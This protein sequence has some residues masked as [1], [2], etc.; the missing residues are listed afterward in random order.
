MLPA[1]L[2]GWH[3]H[4]QEADHCRGFPCPGLPACPLKGLHPRRAAPSTT[5]PWEKARSPEKLEQAW[6]GRAKSASIAGDPDGPSCPGE[7]SLGFSA[8]QLSTPVLGGC[9]TPV[10]Q[11]P[12]TASPLQEPLQPRKARTSLAQLYKICLHCGVILPIIAALGKSPLG[13]Q[14]PSWLLPPLGGCCN[15]EEQLTSTTSPLEEPHSPVTP[16][17]SLPS[18]MKSASIAVQTSQSCLP[19]GSP[20]LL[21][22]DPVSPAHPQEKPCCLK[23]D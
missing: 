15:P 4:M 1:I 8:S 22:R 18:H 7:E 19:S 11:L 17:K 23:E 16:E 5:S 2:E 10:G 12:S 21:Q 6:P 14:R 3:H 20:P 13:S 9:C